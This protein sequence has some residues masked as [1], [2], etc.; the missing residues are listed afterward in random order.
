MK[1]QLVHLKN[2]Q[3]I[4]HNMQ[5]LDIVYFLRYYTVHCLYLQLFYYCNLIYINPVT[6]LSMIMSCSI[7]GIYLTYI[8]PKYLYLE[9]IKID[10]YV[11]GILMKICDILLHHIPF[12]IFIYLEIDTITHSNV[13]LIEMIGIPLFYRLCIDPYKIYKLS[14]INQFLFVFFSIIYSI[15]FTYYL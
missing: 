14:F 9:A 6:L 12:I 2:Y 5:L 8:N 13:E 10:A 15:M 4:F 3:V 7:G 11:D 1:K